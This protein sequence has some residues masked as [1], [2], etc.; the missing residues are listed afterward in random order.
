MDKK[1]ELQRKQQREVLIIIF[2]LIFMLG[3][4]LT[5]ILLSSSNT[6]SLGI[7]TLSG[8]LLLIGSL[9][10]YSQINV[11]YKRSIFAGTKGKVLSV[12]L[13]LLGLTLLLVPLFFPN[14]TKGAPPMQ[15]LF[16]GIVSLG[17]GI[18]QF[19]KNQQGYYDKKTETET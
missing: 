18:R 10:L 12:F 8:S 9:G 17:Y 1:E 19:R 16:G 5:V 3:L 15:G 14:L 2:G 6:S 11:D 7:L 4:S 13:I